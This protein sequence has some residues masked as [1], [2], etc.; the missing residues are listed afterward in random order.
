M[1]QIKK[2]RDLEGNIINLNALS[3]NE[4][5]FLDNVIKDYKTNVEWN[6]FGSYWIGGIGSIYKGKSRKYI[7]ETTLF[8]ICQDLESRLG[9]AQGKTR[10]PDPWE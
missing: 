9:I 3:K 10:L 5:N 2:Y 7:S 6:K 1:K 4:R 8:I